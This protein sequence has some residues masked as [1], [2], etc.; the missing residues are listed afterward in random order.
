MKFFISAL[1]L[2]SVINIGESILIKENHRTGKIPD[3]SPVINLS[4]A[5]KD[6]FYYYLRL[7]FLVLRHIKFLTNRA[8]V[9]KIKY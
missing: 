3:R 1:L 5:N 2:S 6:E 8:I 9:V 4:F 7:K